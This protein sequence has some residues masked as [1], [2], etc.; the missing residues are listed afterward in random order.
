MKS[1]GI[2]TLQLAVGAVALSVAGFASAQ[3]DQ[4]KDAAAPA[5][6][7]A[8]AHKHNGKHHHHHHKG[9]HKHGHKHDRSAS[10]R[11]EA[12]ARQEAQRGTL[13]GGNATQYERN[14]LARC[15][16]FKTDMDRS[17][18]VDRVR[19]GQVSGSVEGGGT[20]TESRQ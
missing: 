6:M 19:Q 5:V 12:A 18:C 13:G 11:E 15:G 8:P 17:A 20:L 3:A 7:A 14:A 16:V 2:R 1:F 9:M 10:S 4:A